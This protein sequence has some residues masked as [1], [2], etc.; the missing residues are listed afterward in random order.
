[1]ESHPEAQPYRRGPI[2]AVVSGLIGWLVL[3]I[4][5]ESVLGI[6]VTVGPR[7]GETVTGRR[8]ELDW[9]A[10]LDTAGVRYEVQVDTLGGDFDPPRDSRTDLE[11]PDLRRDGVLERGTHYIWRVRV[12]RKGTPG[13]WSRVENFR[14][15]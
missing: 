9:N 4:V 3:L 11:E 7:G 15:G 10:P 1:M 5:N 2:L 8:M 13:R 6:P 14:A 12:L